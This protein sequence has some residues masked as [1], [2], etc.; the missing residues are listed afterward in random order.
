MASAQA[1]VKRAQTLVRQSTGSILTSN[2]E[3]ITITTLEQAFA[4]G[5]PLARRVVLEAGHYLG[6]AISSLIGTLNI[7]K[8]ILS[9]IMTRF[10]AVWLD[11]I[12][13]TVAQTSLSRLAQETNVDIGQLGGNRIVLG[14]SALLLG[15]YS[16]LFNL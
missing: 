7:Q 15:D 11:A 4:A 5:D 6:M 14:A 8:I 3:E 9:G 10:G 16:L 2:P 12:R 1:V 13:E